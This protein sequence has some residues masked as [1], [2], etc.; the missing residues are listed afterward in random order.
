MRVAQNIEFRE[1]A[2]PGVNIPRGAVESANQVV[3]NFGNGLPLAVSQAYQWRVHIDHELIDSYSFF[4][5][6]PPAGPVLG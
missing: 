2:I 6:G 5:P 4:V 3:L 1:P